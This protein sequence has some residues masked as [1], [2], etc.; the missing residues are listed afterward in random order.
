[1]MALRDSGRAKLN[2][3]LEV[4]GRRPDGLR[5][6]AQQPPQRERELLT[7]LCDLTRRQLRCRLRHRLV[8]PLGR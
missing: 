5:S 7:R 1:M 2:L 3:T 4:L 8:F 6:L